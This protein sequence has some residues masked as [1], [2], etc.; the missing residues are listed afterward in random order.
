MVVK[1]GRDTAFLFVEEGRILILK[2]S[3]CSVR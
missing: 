3:A 2:D 1:T